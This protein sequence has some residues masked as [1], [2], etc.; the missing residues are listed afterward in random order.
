MLLG[1]KGLFYSDIGKKIGEKIRH[2]ENSPSVSSD[3]SSED[4]IR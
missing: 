4:L 3:K 2:L 1:I